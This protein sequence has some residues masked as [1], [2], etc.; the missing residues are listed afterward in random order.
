MADICC[1]SEVEDEEE[2]VGDEAAGVD[3]VE[4]RRSEELY[5]RFLSRQ[6][7]MEPGYHHHSPRRLDLNQVPVPYRKIDLYYNHSTRYRI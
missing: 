5:R 3:E 1:L 7:E 6:L 2:D 4:G